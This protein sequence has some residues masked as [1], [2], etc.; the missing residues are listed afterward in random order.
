MRYMGGSKRR[1]GSADHHIGITHQY[2]HDNREAQDKKTPPTFYSLKDHL[3]GLI[4]NGILNEKEKE[5]I[6]KQ[7]LL[8]ALNVLI[9]DIGE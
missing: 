6:N 7:L 5:H 1:V 3:V 8:H 2:H 9:L 4:I